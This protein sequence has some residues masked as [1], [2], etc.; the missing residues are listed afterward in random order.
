VPVRTPRTWIDPGTPVRLQG[1]MRNGS[2]V[3]AD[4][5]SA[6]TRT[7]GSPLQADAAP[8]AAAPSVENTA[9][10]LVSFASGGPTW[11]GAG[12]PTQPQATS[13]MFDAPGAA[14]TH[15]ADSLKAYY[16]EQTYGQ[17]SFSGTVFGPV[18]IPGPSSACGTTSS[19]FAV[20][21]DS[22]YTWLDDAEQAVGI[23]PSNDSAWKH[24]VVA[25]PAGV[26]CTDVDGAA[27][28]AE[29]G[30]NHVWINGSFLVPVLAHELGHNLGLFHA[31]GL[32]CTNAGSATPQPMGSSC[33]ADTFEYKDPFDAM[34]QSDPGTGTMVLRQMNM[35]H[36]LLLDVVPASAQQV[37][38]ISGLY[39]V[40]PMETLTGT[41]EVLRLPRPGGGSYYVEYRYPVAG[42]FF[43]NQ[44]PAFNG[45]YVRTES[46]QPVGY[47]NGSDTALIDMH[48]TTGPPSA[49]WA[50]AR[51]TLGQ[52]FSDPLRG[53]VI[54][55][56]AEDANGATLA[57][58]MPIDTTPPSRPARLSAI[59]SGSDVA[60]QWT[61][62]SD[63]FG[64]A[65]YVVTRDGVQTG[66]TTGTTYGDTG[67]AP[68][69]TVAY[70]V[71][72]VDTAGNVGP[73]ATVTVTSPDTVPPSLPAGVT[74][75]VTRDGQ[76]H[77]AWQPS[78]DNVGVTSYRVL[79][80][81]TGIVQMNVRSYVDPAPRP[82]SGATVTYSVVAFD[83]IGNASPPGLAKPL[84]SA[85]LRKLG[86]SHLKV[87][88][89]KKGRRGSVRVTGI[90]SDA[91]AVCRLRGAGSAWHS[92]KTRANGSFSVSLAVRRV[93]SITLSLRD[94]LGRVKQQSLRV[95]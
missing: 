21:H 53:I 55:D 76:V 93:K 61:P 85:L 68:G 30:G 14:L 39:H 8:L 32:Q 71:S 57:I 65:S 15:S 12:D 20:E 44:S 3:L 75:T 91:K 48:P 45:V 46:P 27:G 62:A 67:I 63:D 51:M 33:S 42:G 24:V 88:R 1:T 73:A 28:L 2:L 31:G 16:Q 72:A 7:G 13:L 83:V 78:A 9:V 50:D 89:P 35:E 49:P 95:P 90:V 23:N 26:T 17:I 5:L 77:V 92:C 64:I 19:N 11:P 36:K 6:V 4:S 66:T 38:G 41:A 52:V 74:A 82:G 59:L 56:M 79:R 22:L 18:T 47:P 84:R 10:I 37:I 54:Q 69:A 80:N 86:A 34:G 60:L 81:G 40:A 94:E 70:G 29:V 58:T 87:T 43:D 25:L